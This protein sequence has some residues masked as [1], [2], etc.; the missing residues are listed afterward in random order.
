VLPFAHLVTARDWPR[1]WQWAAARSGHAFDAA[2]KNPSSHYA[3]PAV[4]NPN[5]PRV[6]FSR[7]GAL[8]SP[9]DEGLVDAIPAIALVPQGPTDGQPSVM[10]GLD[11]T[12]Q[13]LDHVDRDTVYLT[14]DPWEDDAVTSNDPLMQAPAAVHEL[15]SDEDEASEDVS[16]DDGAGVT[17]V[18]EVRTSE[19]TA[20]HSSEAKSPEAAGDP[21]HVFFASIESRL[22]SI[23]SRL[24][25]IESIGTSL[26]RIE[27]LE[28]L[29][30]LHREGVIDAEE[31]ER[32]KRMV[33]ADR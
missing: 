6:A 10:R 25:S 15:A 21:L 24:A 4:P 9:M 20:S 32:A 13:Y 26:S 11:P 33:L 22:A 7:P 28:R 31:L 29:A 3:L 1:V 23:E 18:H 16:S 5:W 12:R 19:R 17:A 14:D 27:S 2:L 8:L 30:R